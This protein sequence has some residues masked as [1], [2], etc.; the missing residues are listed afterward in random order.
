M[1]RIFIMLTLACTAML[2]TNTAWAGKPIFMERGPFEFMFPIFDCSEFE[3]MDYW[4]W[5]AGASMEEGKIFVDKDG[6][7]IKTV[8]KEYMSDLNIWIPA[9]PGCNVVPFTDCVD[10][11]MPMPG[12]N[13]ITDEGIAGRPEN[14]NVIWRDWIWVDHDP[15]LPEGEGYWYPTYG[16]HSG[17][18]MHIWIPGYGKIFATAGHMTHQFNPETHQWDLLSI[19]PNW[20]QPKEKDFYAACAYLGKM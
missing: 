5:A 17:I 18:T 1:K 15:N 19:T 20:D 8:G 3:G 7:W 10:P 12:S 6:N 4:L 16:Q 11:F 13:I 2:T 14:H 9:D